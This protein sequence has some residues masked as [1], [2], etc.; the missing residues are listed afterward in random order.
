MHDSDSTAAL[1]TVPDFVSNLSTELL[2][3]LFFHIIN[4]LQHAQFNETP[5]SPLDVFHVLVDCIKKEND[6]Q[7]AVVCNSKRFTSQRTSDPVG[8]GCAQLVT[9]LRWHSDL[10]QL[11]EKVLTSQ[12]L[13]RKK[14]AAL[15]RLLGIAELIM[16]RHASSTAPITAPVT[17]D[18]NGSDFEFIKHYVDESV[19]ASHGDSG[20]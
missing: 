18:H 13:P 5:L 2:L 10:T 6:T 14:A 3:A 4:D 11:G 16:E 12:T 1:A 19:T 17:I 15:E 7:A 20:T 8:R 9:F